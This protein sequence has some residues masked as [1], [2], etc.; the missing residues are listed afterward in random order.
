MVLTVRVPDAKPPLPGDHA[1]EAGTWILRPLGHLEIRPGASFIARF[2]G[3]LTGWMVIVLLSARLAAEQQQPHVRQLE[4]LA[5]V[6]TLFSA[7]QGTGADGTP[8][9]L[10]PARG[11][12]LLLGTGLSPCRS[13]PAV[14]LAVALAFLAGG[15]IRVFTAA[16]CVV[17]QVLF[18]VF[19]RLGPLTPGRSSPTAHRRNFTT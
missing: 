6:L 19:M 10:D 11:C 3:G 8:G 9:P 4:V 7:I 12:W 14:V 15:W 16:A 13:P 17:W 5:I 1:E 18:L 2:T